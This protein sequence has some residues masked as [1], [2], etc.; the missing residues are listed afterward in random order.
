M[1]KNR[2]I[3]DQHHAYDAS[4]IAIADEI[5]SKYYLIM[6]KEVITKTTGNS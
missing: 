1:R 6:M 4:I 3:G 2:D 5:I